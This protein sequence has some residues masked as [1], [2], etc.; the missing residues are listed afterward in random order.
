M[1][2]PHRGSG[3]A[4]WADWLAQGLTVG[5]LH[6]GGNPKF[7]AALKKNSKELSRISEQYVNRHNDLGLSVRT[8]FELE[9]TGNQ[10]VSAQYATYGTV[11]S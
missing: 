10:V 4:D 7:V 11:M 8:F 2:T 6:F 5:R 3:L 1:G 9:T